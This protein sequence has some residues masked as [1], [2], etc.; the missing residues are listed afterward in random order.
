MSSRGGHFLKGDISAFDA[1]FFKMSG[2]E[3]KAMDPQLRLL[4]ETAYHA[5]ESGSSAVT[6]CFFFLLVALTNFSVAGIS[7]DALRASATSVYIGSIVQ[8]YSAMVAY[9]AELNPPYQATGNSGSMHSNR[10][11]WFYDLRGPSV[12]IDTACSSSLVGIHLAC[13]SLIQGEAD[14]VKRSMS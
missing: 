4:L 13:Q 8:E 10:L 12:T 1:A 11:S 7:L 6:L 14:M 9:D 2:A 3:A 5:F